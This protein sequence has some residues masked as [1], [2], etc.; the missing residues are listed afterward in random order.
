M[1][2]ALCAGFGWLPEGFSDPIRVSLG[3]PLSIT[4]L[5]LLTNAAKFHA[6]K[7]CASQGEQNFWCIT[8]WP[9]QMHTQQIK[10]KRKW[11]ETK[12]EPAL[13]LKGA[14]LLLSK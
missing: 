12:P 7:H 10:L 8:T 13:S 1:I 9:A 2:G 3:S 14:N 6:Q 4:F 5:S 11:N